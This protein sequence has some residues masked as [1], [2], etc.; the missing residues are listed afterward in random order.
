MFP[1]DQLEKK[2]NG[3]KKIKKTEKL[4]SERVLKATR[5]KTQWVNFKLTLSQILVEDIGLWG[6]EEGRKGKGGGEGETEQKE[7]REK[8]R[9]KERERKGKGK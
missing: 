8:S 1:I 4:P 6:R 7:E 3:G 5:H 9:W 2:K